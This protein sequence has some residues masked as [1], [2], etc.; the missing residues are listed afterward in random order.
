MQG[1]YSPII[2]DGDTIFKTLNFEEIVRKEFSEQYSG[3]YEI[4]RPR[5]NKIALFD[6]FHHKIS[7]NI[8]D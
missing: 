5:H 3:N 4:W 1:D 6:N 8:L 7:H 2:L